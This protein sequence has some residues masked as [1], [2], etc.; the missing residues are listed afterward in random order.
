MEY[1]ITSLNSVYM[2]DIDGA[3]C[4]LYIGI[5]AQDS[6][7]SGLEW[8]FVLYNIHMMNTSRM[9]HANKYEDHYDEVTLRRC[10]TI[11]L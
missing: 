5:F 10:K 9:F 3:T 6:E 1:C 4:N 11:I 2:N 8:I 7:L